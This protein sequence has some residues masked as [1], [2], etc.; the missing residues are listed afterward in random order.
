MVYF[1]ILT[2]GRSLYLLI[3]KEKCLVPNSYK[4]VEIDCKVLGKIPLY[5]LVEIINI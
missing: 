2:T 5:K 3:I 1:F 4:L